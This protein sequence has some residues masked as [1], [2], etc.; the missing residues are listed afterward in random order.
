MKLPPTLFLFLSDLL[1]TNG[2]QGVQTQ[3][4]YFE[5]APPINLFNILIYIDIFMWLSVSTYAYHAYL[6]CIYFLAE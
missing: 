6:K 2:V 1:G 3:N 4:G 5:L